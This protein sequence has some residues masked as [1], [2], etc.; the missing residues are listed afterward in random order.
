MK[1]KTEIRSS[2][3]FILLA[4]LALFVLSAPQI[5]RHLDSKPLL[6]GDESYYH[7][8]IARQIADEGI[9]KHDNLAYSKRAYTFNPYHIILAALSA[10]FGVLLSSV[11]LPF[12]C[13]L[14]SVLL[15]YLILKKLGFSRIN[16][17]MISCVFLLSPVF[18]HTFSL[19]SPLCVV[20]LL[21]LLGFF[22]F[23]HKSNKLFIASLAVLIFAS[24]FG[25][26]NL[27][28]VAA[29]A[30]SYA[31]ARRKSM[32][33]FYALLF[34]LLL[35]FMFHYLNVYFESGFQLAAGLSET[36][37][38][39]QFITDLGGMFGF[40]IFTLLL[41][42]LGL[43]A[44]WESKK[45]YYY[46]YLIMIAVVI[47]SFFYNPAV[48]YSNFA[49]SIL[50]G[51]ALSK[52]I[53]RKWELKVIRNLSIMLLFCGLL[54]SAVSYSVRISELQPNSEIVEALDWINENSQSDEIVFSHYTKG[55]WIGFWA[56]RTAL[57]DSFDYPSQRIEDSRSIFSS[58]DIEST[59]GL[60]EKYNVSI[61]L[62]TADMAEGLVWDKREQGLEYLLR[63]NK[64]FKK[65]HN[66]SYAG[67]W[68]YIYAENG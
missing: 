6:A 7:A 10:A 44:V 61:L 20:I 42:A 40:S 67:V 11:I 26:L 38:V 54:F 16:R 50:A 51:T 41:S 39:K 60:I 64:T 29:A 3:L 15:F 55:F 19:S 25:L 13:G 68:R 17:I 53:T 57:A 32:N 2:Q 66:N 31:L 65:V 34:L 37:L 49:V 4:L 45:K 27:I 14:A 56:E 46:T 59:K 36:G 9:P 43:V 35:V 48:A 28:M 63:N 52:L 1:E 23:M 58:W 8:R 24:F 12:A 33:R 62:I 47:A 21:D 5:M 30:L 22:I 18:M